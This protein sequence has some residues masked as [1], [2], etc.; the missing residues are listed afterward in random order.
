MKEKKIIKESSQR[1]RESYER[2]FE[3]FNIEEFL[4]KFDNKKHLYLLKRHFEADS[5]WFKK[6]FLKMWNP[7]IKMI[8]D[9]IIKEGN[10][11]NNIII[12]KACIKWESKV[13]YIKSKLNFNPENFISQFD[14]EKH[15]YLLKRHFEADS[16]WFKKK[17]FNFSKSKA[18][19]ILNDVL[20]FDDYEK[21]PIIKRLLTEE[22]KV[23][24]RYR[25]HKRKAEFNPEKFIS[26][27][28]NKEQL[29]LMNEYLKADREWFITK[30]YRLTKASGEKYLKHILENKGKGYLWEF[31]KVIKTI[32]KKDDFEM[33]KS[34]DVKKFIGSFDNSL[35]KNFLIYYFEK[36][37]EEFREK[38]FKVKKSDV[39]KFCKKYFWIN[40]KAPAIIYK[41]S[42]WIVQREYY[43]KTNEERQ[44][45]IEKR[46]QEK[47]KKKY[48][49]LDVDTFLK[50][51]S[52]DK[53]KYDFLEN[54]L[55]VD[56]EE[57]RKIFYKMTKAKALKYMNKYLW[58]KFISLLCVPRNN[59]W[60]LLKTYYH[61]KRI[62]FFI[63]ELN[64]DPEF[65]EENP[66]ILKVVSDI[67]T[68]AND[69]RDK[70]WISYIE[71]NIM[72]RRSK[73][74]SFLW[75]DIAKKLIAFEK[76]WLKPKEVWGI[77]K[78]S[79][80][81]W[82]WNI[83]LRIKESKELW[84]TNFELW[85]IYRK[86]NTF[87]MSNTK[88]K[89]KAFKEFWL[90][91]IAFWRALKNF[92]N[93]ISTSIDNKIR[94]LY[95]LNIYFHHSSKNNNIII[96]NIEDSYKYLNEFNKKEINFI[97]KT[98]EEDFLIMKILI[99]TNKEK[100]YEDYSEYIL[101]KNTQNWWY[102]QYYQDFVKFF[103]PSR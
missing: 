26:Q 87:F 65:I 69:F 20:K 35:T 46:K 101:K 99:T 70:L 12:T 57:F 98:F 90:T 88:N 27:F 21:N 92:P 80:R 11:E 49:R 22:Q 2:A 72:I 78:Y 48:M 66:S 84:L 40:S 36:D 32:E 7:K 38:Y 5:E 64:I 18:E 51:F 62:D 42:L 74:W 43:S 77:I 6:K 97:N 103:T 34:F 10:Y 47:E 13:R 93:I 102:A 75:H 67:R 37:E 91:P 96:E 9:E 79:I 55:K 76:I 31:L 29:F 100:I 73:I 82:N 19:K 1:R 39:E 16:E 53:E 15:L 81:A 71:L 59:F 3:N 50:Y 83:P 68:K 14:N 94:P 4:L 25:D 56:E 58:D 60:K 28:E 45:E 86:Y 61:Q 41:W 23:G 85:D 33:Q 89:I 8:L 52:E 30:F 54:F 63:N 95:N 44:K 17:F 24:K